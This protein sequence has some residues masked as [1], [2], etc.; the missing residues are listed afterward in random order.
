MKKG[1]RQNQKE[2]G[3]KKGARN[4]RGAKKEEKPAKR[5]DLDVALDVF[6]GKDEKVAKKEAKQVVQKAN[7]DSELDSYM[8]SASN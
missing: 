3:N 7:L 1:G 5:E 2:G 6:M 4:N 8:A